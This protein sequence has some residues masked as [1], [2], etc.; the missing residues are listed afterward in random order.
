MVHLSQAF[1]VQLSPSPVRIP[2]TTFATPKHVAMMADV[3]LGTLITFL[4]SHTTQTSAGCTLKSYSHDTGSGPV[5]VMVHGYPQ[6]AY[7]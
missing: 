7:M 6:S 1:Q 5:L 2:Y 3:N 4:K